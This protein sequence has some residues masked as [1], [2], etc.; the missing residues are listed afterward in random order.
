M[1]EDTRKSKRL[2]RVVTQ[3]GE[4]KTEGKLEQRGRPINYDGRYI[5]YRDV[6]VRKRETAGGVWSCRSTNEDETSLTE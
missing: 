3:D 5:I 4:P 6:T 2:L 1:G